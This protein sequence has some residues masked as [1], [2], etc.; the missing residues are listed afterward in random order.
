MQIGD[1]GDGE[2]LALA[3]AGRR[4]PVIG[5]DEIVGGLGRGIGRR[6]GHQD[7]GKAGQAEARLEQAAAG[8]AACLRQAI[9]GFADGH[10]AEEIVLEL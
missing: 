7:A 10:L 5:D 6:A 1:G 2:F 9:G 3:P 8:E 4:Q